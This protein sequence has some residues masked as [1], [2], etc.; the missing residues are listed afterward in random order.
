MTASSLSEAS[1][2][3][4]EGLRDDG[5]ALLR[6][7]YDRHEMSRVDAML[8]IAFCRE[9]Q[10]GE[11]ERQLPNIAH[12]PYVLHLIFRDPLFEL[13]AAVFEGCP[14]LLASYGHDK[15]PGTG[16]HTAPHSDVAHIAGFPHAERLFMLKVCVA[17]RPFDR[18]QAPTALWTGT[19]RLARAAD[20]LP[21]LP[22]LERGDVLLFDANLRHSATANTSGVARRTMWMTFG[23]SY[24]RAFPGY[25]FTGSADEP[26]VRDAG[27]DLGVLGLRNPYST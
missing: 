5:Y 27:G 12:R 2:S 13:L 14:H 11:L 3:A 20:R 24:M 4:Y 25:E 21:V 22:T 16:A 10:K 17:C 1:R 9:A 18:D 23:Y 19:H 26:R 6:G 15:P 7:V 8:S